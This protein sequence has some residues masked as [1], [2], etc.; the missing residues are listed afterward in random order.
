M[1]YQIGQ[2]VEITSVTGST[3]SGKVV[4]IRKQRGNDFKMHTYAIVEFQH[5][6]S[7]GIFKSYEAIKIK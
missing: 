2:T 6:S 1:T 7:D 3:E 5:Q 4:E